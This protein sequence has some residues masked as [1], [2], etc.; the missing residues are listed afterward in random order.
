M[1][2]NTEVDEAIEKSTRLTILM[3]EIFGI[4]SNP[5]EIIRFAFNIISSIVNV[6]NDKNQLQITQR[7]VGLLNE[8][9]DIELNEKIGVLSETNN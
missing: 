3:A 2:K 9:L 8:K 1:V 5:G 4:T 7:L 6:I